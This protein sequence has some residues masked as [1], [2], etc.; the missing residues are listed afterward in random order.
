MSHLVARTVPL[1]EG[2][3]FLAD[4]DTADPMAELVGSPEWCHAAVDTVGA[5]ALRAIVFHEAQS[6]PTDWVGIVVLERRRAGW[7]SGSPGFPMWQW[8]M[9]E[10]GYGF[11]PRFQLNKLP[12]SHSDWWVPL[13]V[14]VGRTRL[15][16]LRC[17]SNF[18][19][20]SELLDP[21]THRTLQPLSGPAV[22]AGATGG[23]FDEWRKRLQTRHVRSFDY[24]SRRIRRE[25]GQWRSFSTIEQTP[26]D[27]EEAL[28]RVFRLHALRVRAKGQRSAYLTR[29]GRRFLIALSRH[30]HS[31]LQLRL[32]E[33]WIDSGAVAGALSFIKNGRFTCFM[34][35]WHP[36]FSHLD[37]GRQVIYAQI[38][39]E[40]EASNR[41]DVI[42]LLGGDLPYKAEFGLSPHST[43]NWIAARS[44]F[45]ARREH[46]VTYLRT[47]RRRTSPSPPLK[48]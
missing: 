43:L 40:W 17:D 1:A 19:T 30:G 37:L 2:F 3:R 25:N 33:L 16:L 21:F 46:A 7:R 9:A 39:N 10:F 20:A 47:H 48:N 14:H 29:R 34:P 8:P 35:G 36:N 45:A 15:E 28:K 13:R 12:L 27:V 18:G 42:D 38:T 6:A 11:R 31:K 5:D 4:L 22:W 26:D 23:S 44:S 41:I 32:T 24:Y